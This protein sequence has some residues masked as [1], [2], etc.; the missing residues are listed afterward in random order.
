MSRAYWFILGAIFFSA[1]GAAQINFNYKW[2]YPSPIAIW[3][4]PGGKLLGD[5]PENDKLLADCKPVTV[6]GED[7]KPKTVQKC[8]VVFLDEFERL[9]IDY[10]Q[11]KQRVID[12]E[13]QCNANPR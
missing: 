1:C 5:K 11:T 12:L 13:R 3:D 2:Y 7:G 10:K 4:F 8:A 9:V 6:P